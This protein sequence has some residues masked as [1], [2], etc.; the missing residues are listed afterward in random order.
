M[1]FDGE[2]YMSS[3]SGQKTAVTAHFKLEA[4]LDNEAT[5]A[6]G[7]VAPEITGSELIQA[8]NVY[9]LS[10]KSAP[11]TQVGFDVYREAIYIEEHVWI[12]GREAEVVST[13]ATREHLEKYPKEWERFE[14]WRDTIRDQHNLHLLKGADVAAVKTLHGIGIV[15]VE[16]LVACEREL[17]Q[18]LADLRAYGKRFLAFMSGA[19]PR[20]R[21]V[22]GEIQEVEA[23]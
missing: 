3:L 23:A 12:D 1:D 15:T 17:P 14:K 16:Q 22:N 18:N 6:T 21:I 9:T 2:A 4:E 10:L 13:K 19:K 7:K 8:G 11:Q 20:Y 5:Q